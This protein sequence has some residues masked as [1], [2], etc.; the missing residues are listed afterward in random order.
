MCVWI[1]L[2]GILS[3]GVAFGA[4]SWCLFQGLN[5]HSYGVGILGKCRKAFYRCG[6]RECGD[7][8]VI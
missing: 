7:V 3:G 8:N 2:C 6:K 4:T 1:V 5:K